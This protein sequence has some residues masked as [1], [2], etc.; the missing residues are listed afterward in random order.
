[1][2][3]IREMMKL[4]VFRNMRLVGSEIYYDNEIDSIGIFE[5]EAIENQYDLFRKGDFVITTLM[6]AKDDSELVEKSL[7]RLMKQRVSAIAI[8]DIYYQS[9]SEN[10]IDYANKHHIQLMFFDDIP[11]EDIIVS[12]SDEIRNKEFIKYYE[13]RIDRI[14]D[15]RPKKEETLSIINEINGSFLKSSYCAYAVPRTNNT[16]EKKKLIDAVMQNVR[17]RKNKGANSIHNNIFRYK[18]GIFIIH[19]FNRCIHKDGYL[20]SLIKNIGIDRETFKIGISDDHHELYHI[21]YGIQQ[22]LSSY[23]R[24]LSF[25][26]LGIDMFL[27]PLRKNYWADAYINKIIGPII[28]H[29]KVSSFKLLE[30]AESFIKNRGELKRTADE[31]DQHVN[32]IRHRLKRIRDIIDYKEDNNDFYEQLF[33]A[34]SLYQ[35]KTP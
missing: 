6:Y 35:N 12:V 3:K 15:D 8:K 9:L 26:M 7:I 17:S 16:K 21:T 4:E 14:L 13:T 34:I 25:N 28:E 32:T 33:I 10:V 24:D 2:I 20:K 19:T 5:Y 23:Q 22:A 18:G 31:M 11:F 1:M 27:M 30:T 29:D